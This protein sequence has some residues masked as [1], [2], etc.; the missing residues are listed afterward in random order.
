MKLHLDSNIIEG[1]P[2]EIIEYTQLL[3]DKSKAIKEEDNPAGYVFWYLEGYK[4]KRNS[5]LKAS[6]D[7]YFEDSTG[8]RYTYQAVSSF[9]QPLNKK[10]GK[11]LFELFEDAKDK[12]ALLEYY[13][14]ADVFMNSY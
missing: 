9:V 6:I 5:V 14:S 8:K 10:D 13:S 3:K 11:E 1:T 7:G 4:L 12:G 2:E